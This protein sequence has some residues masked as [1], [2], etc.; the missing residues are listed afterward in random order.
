MLVPFKEG[1][2]HLSGEPEG[3]SYLIGSKCQVCGAVAFPRRIVCHKCHSE[4]VVEVP[5]GKKGTLAS[6]IVSW[7]APAGFTPP[8][9]MGYI[10]M[11]EGVRFLSIITGVEPSP[12][13]LEF[14]QQMELVIEKLRTDQDGNDV[15]AFKFR[16]ASS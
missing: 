4:D 7:A 5:L 10:D 8:L 9:T 14:G 15:I 12:H 6:Y 13:A 11:P 2:M 16:P 1:V 3:E